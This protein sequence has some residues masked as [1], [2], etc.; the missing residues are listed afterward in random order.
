M[1]WRNVTKESSHLKLCFSYIFGPMVSSPLL[2][3]V[4][5][6]PAVLA[7]LGSLLEMQHLNLDLL[8]SVGLHQHS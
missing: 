3:N 4:I 6:G 2:L 8:E 5:H 1:I 7:L